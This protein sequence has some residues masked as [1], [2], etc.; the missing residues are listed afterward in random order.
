MPP[1]EE[2]AR[3]DYTA[4]AVHLGVLE[5]SQRNILSG[6]GEI[7]NTLNDYGDRLGKVEV[8]HATLASRVEV[9]DKTQS[10]GRPQPGRLW[11]ILSSLTGLVVIVFFILDRFYQAAH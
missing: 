1:E 10:E 2:V 4:I 6:I 9:M 8:G 5:E 7:K 3:T 11:N